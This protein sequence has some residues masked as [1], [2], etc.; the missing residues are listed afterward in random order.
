[1]KRTR[2]WRLATAAVALSALTMTIT[3]PALAQS[4]EDLEPFFEGLSESEI[5]QVRAALEGEG[6]EPLPE[7]L[8]AVVDQILAALAGEGEGGEDV[9]TEDADETTDVDAGGA[10]DTPEAGVGGF[11]GYAHASG[12]TVCVG[13]PAELREGLAP[14][15]DG[16][17]IAG[18]CD[19][20]NLD[21][22]R[23][24]LA[25]TQATLQRAAV[26]ED[27]SSEA[28]A[29]LTNLI[30]GSAEAG[31]P[32]SCQGGPMDIA[33]PEDSPVIELTVLGV[34]CAETDERAFADVKIAGL[35]IR[36][37]NMI[38]HGLP[39]EL[40]AGLGDGIDQFNEQLLAAV[41]EGLCEG[42]DPIFEGLVGG[43]SLCEEGET[44]LQLNNPLD[45]D[46]PL[47][48]LEVVT[49]TSEV[50]H[51]DGTVTANASASLTGLNVLGISCLGG[52]GTAPYE[53]TSTATTDGETATRSADAPD[54]QLRACSQEQSLLR[55]LMS[56][57]DPL[58]DIA[59]VEQVVQDELLEGNFA[60]LFAGLNEL[61]T[62]LETRLLWQGEAYTN[63]ID[64]AGTSAGTKP[65]A[66]LA[67]LPLSVLGDTPL[68]DIGVA[69][70]GNETAV[71][72]NATPAV[73][74]A[75]APPAPAAPT[76][77]EPSAPLP[78]TGAG[79]AG[80]LGLAAIGGAAALRRRDR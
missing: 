37:G 39:E 17:G 35:D 60:E 25:Q 59:L 68:G 38:A 18:S 53:F 26:G 28:Q 79:L 62:A 15:L 75:G 32:G 51:D 77:G 72:V 64:G 13:L 48:D 47:V 21:G 80:L 5:S 33:I 22:I 8:Q 41:G 58:G 44:F 50:V 57:D 12:T 29:L 34:D 74:P 65:F 67:T 69:V 70:V 49:A 63:A 52:D 27:V 76:P 78:H 1:L 2:T 23:I 20:V 3:G 40:R 71:G 56:S 31:A 61:L 42:T 7:E 19:E 55:S 24:D 73:T 16:L 9:E 54:L 10:A 36:L 45:A 30:L 43:G 11:T 14:L 4:H 66:V 6:D 46:V